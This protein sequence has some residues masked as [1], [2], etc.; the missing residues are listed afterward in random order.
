M[1]SLANVASRARA[2][3]RGACLEYGW[4]RVSTRTSIPYSFNKLTNFPAE[5]LEC[6]MVNTQ[7]FT[8]PLSSIAF[9]FPGNVTDEG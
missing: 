5:W 1:P 6:P 8:A 9:S 7:F 4:E 2:L 3:K